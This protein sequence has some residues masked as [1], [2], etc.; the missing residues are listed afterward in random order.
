MSFPP[1]HNW[2]V[3]PFHIFPHLFYTRQLLL[4]RLRNTCMRNLVAYCPIRTLDSAK[5]LLEA[6]SQTQIHR[7]TCANSGTYKSVRYK[8]QLTVCLFPNISGTY[9]HTDTD[10]QQNDV[11]LNF[12]MFRFLHSLFIFST[13]IFDV[14]FFTFL[15]YRVPSIRPTPPP[16]QIQGVSLI[17]QVGYLKN[18]SLIWWSIKMRLHSRKDKC[19]PKKTLLKF[20]HP[21]LSY[22]RFSA[23]EISRTFV[24]VE[25]VRESA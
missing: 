4:T 13:T 5:L 10:L 6:F 1:P 11:S 18:F 8:E 24:N 7:L 15:I 3:C 17:R 19:L 12:F 14:C 2:L 9:P 20:I 22:G 21:K 16:P 25:K 23:S